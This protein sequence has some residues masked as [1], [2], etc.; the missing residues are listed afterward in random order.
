MVQTITIQVGCQ[1][2]STSLASPPARCAWRDH[3]LNRPRFCVLTGLR[4]RMIR[5]RWPFH[6]LPWSLLAT[7]TSK[8]ISAPSLRSRYWISV[9]AVLAG[10]VASGRLASSSSGTTTVPSVVSCPSAGLGR[11]RGSRRGHAAVL[12]QAPT[13]AGMCHTGLAAVAWRK[14]R[15][16]HWRAYS[17][18]LPQCLCPCPDGII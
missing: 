13:P 11:H 17:G 1:R 10:S 15:V 4:G 7:C 2:G 9:W 16:R 12:S 5:W 14:S 6:S 3:V 18:Q 8:P